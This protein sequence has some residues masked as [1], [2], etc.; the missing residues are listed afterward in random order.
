MNQKL[1][2][3]K[4]HETN[5]GRAARREMPTSTAEAI[6]LELAE[7][8]GEMGA[9]WGVTPA[10]ARVQAYL[11]A[12][13]EPL[14]EREVREALGLSPS[15]GEP[16]PRRGRV[17]GHRRAGVR[18]RVGSAGADRRAPRILAVGDHWQ[19]FGRVIAERKVR[20]GDPIVAVLEA[21]AKEAADAS[22]ANPDDAELAA[23]ARLA[24]GV[25]RLR[26][27]LRSGGRARAAA[28]AARARAVAAAPR[29]RAGRDDP[30]PVR[31]ARRP[32]RRRRPR[33]G[34]CAL[35]PVAE[36]CAPRDEAHVGGRPDGLPLGREPADE[37]NR[38]SIDRDVPGYGIP[39]ST[40]GVLPW[41]WAVERLE[42]ADDRTG[43]RR[44]SGRRA[45]PDPDLGRMGRWTTGTSRAGR[46]AGSATCGRTRRWRSTSE[47]NGGE[48]VI[49][50]GRAPWS[51]WR[52]RETLA[53]A[54]PGRLR[55]VPARV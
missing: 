4:A 17:V 2:T 23:L 12:R 47:P 29:P 30:A 14:T 3:V 31:P 1:A 27:A 11:M 46:P 35:A 37:P 48:V 19:W 13:Q 40:K 52:R 53:D 45:A 54:D 20:E 9:A 25:P 38:A 34:R 44:R 39:T 42:R 7:A 55:E 24:G 28:R 21:K 5:G 6:R 32:R 16:R 18:N 36:G 8:W 51:W 43:S 22:A 50:E 10:I 15:R 49:V 41:S 26:P 33:A